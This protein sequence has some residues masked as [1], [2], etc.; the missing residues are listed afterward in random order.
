MIFAAL[1]HDGAHR[2]FLVAR[3]SS[4]L[5]PKHHGQGGH[6][7]IGEGHEYLEPGASLS[8]VNGIQLKKGWRT[9]KAD[10]NKQIQ[11]L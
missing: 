2:L 8:N 3:D 10:R 9:Q 1:V 7:A 4:L 6:I 11:T 5:W